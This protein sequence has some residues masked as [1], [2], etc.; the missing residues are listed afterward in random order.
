MWYFTGIKLHATKSIDIM[1][2]WLS[3]L[4]SVNSS[5]LD[6]QLASSL[7]PFLM[8]NAAETIRYTSAGWTTSGIESFSM[9]LLDVFYPVL[10]D[11]SGV[12]YEANVGTGNTKAVLAFGVFTENTTVYNAGISHDTSAPCSGL[13]V[14]IIASGQSSESGR[15]QAHTQLGL[16]NLAE[17]C[18]IS[19][20]QYS[21]DL[22][23]LLS[24]RLLAGYEYTADYN[25]GSTVSY[26]ASFQRCDADLLGGPF[27][28]ISATD[29]GEFRP[30]Y[31]IAYAHYATI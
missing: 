5:Y 27:T 22:W 21:E 4:K 29:R 9:M 10:N 2:V 3:T 8:T 16:G 30:V 11:F 23:S 25:L 1:N 12:Q 15:D 14:D 31:E 18:T 13:S 28:S 6:K 7:G 19:A 17:S 24:N 20:N 26:N